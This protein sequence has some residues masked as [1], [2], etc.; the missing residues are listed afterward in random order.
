MKAPF[1]DDFW[2]IDEMEVSSTA[3]PSH[4]PFKRFI[5]FPQTFHVGLPPILGHLE[6]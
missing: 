1:G 5:A 4:H 2:D 6:I 3:T